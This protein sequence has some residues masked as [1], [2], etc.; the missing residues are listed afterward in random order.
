IKT[1]ILYLHGEVGEWWK[2]YEEMNEGDDITWKEFKELFLDEFFPDTLRERKH[3]E[4][5]NLHNRI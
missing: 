5:V 1:A 4:F 3:E 2:G